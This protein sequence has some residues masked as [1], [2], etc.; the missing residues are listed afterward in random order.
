MRL[1]VF[2]AGA[3]GGYLAAKLAPVADVDLSLVARGP[4]LA[5]IKADGLRL[6]EDGNEIVHRITASG[7]AA[8]LG[9]QDC[10]ILCLKAHSISPALDAIVPLIGPDTV[11]VTAQNGVPWWYFYRSGGPLEG[12]RI[13]AVDPGGRIWDR[14]GPGAGDRLRR[15]PGRRSRRAGRR[16]PCRGRPVPA[17]R[18][19]RREDRQDRRDRPDSCRRR[20]QGAGPRRYPQRHLGEAVGQPRLQ[21]DLRADRRHP[22]RPVRRS[23]HPRRGARHD[24]R[25]PGDRREARR[26]LPGRCRPPHRGRRRRRRR[27]RP[28]CCRTSNSAGRWRSTPSSPPS[29]SSAAWSACRRRRSIRSSPSS[30]TSP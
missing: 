10:V 26:Q 23:R 7:D 2:G 4:H 22:G 19:F 28:R 12:T 13:E 15:L 25:G 9:P 29:R 5:A 21:P 3:I 16:P 6:I 8:E 17:R 11:V 30:A 14:I 1:C 24:G 20:A 18:A 27:T